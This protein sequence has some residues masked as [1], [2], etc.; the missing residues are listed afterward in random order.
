MHVRSG[1]GEGSGTSR[2][3]V[4]E[5]PLLPTTFLPGCPSIRL[6]GNSSS[7]LSWDGLGSHLDQ[8]R[9][10]P[11]VTHSHHQRAAASQ[12]AAALPAQSG[13]Q[14]WS[15]SVPGARRLSFNSKMQERHG[16]LWVCSCVEA[17]TKP[18][19]ASKA[20][21]QSPVGIATRLPG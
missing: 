4:I 7:L 3:S 9:G 12:T 17:P 21:Q 2:W 11:G 6:E 16:E 20:T 18:H 8:V 5:P 19:P 1:S 14:E 15:S 10:V 13:S